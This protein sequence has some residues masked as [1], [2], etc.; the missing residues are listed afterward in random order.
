MDF[1]QLES[2]VA[3]YRQRNLTEAAKQIAISQQGLSK[4]IQRLEQE[5]ESPLFLR[6]KNRLI[7]T[8][9]GDLFYREAVDLLERYRQSMEVLARA[10][11]RQRGL[12]VGF[13]SNVAGML[14]FEKLLNRFSREFPDIPLDILSETDFVCEEK[15]LKGELDAAFC[16]GPFSSAAIKSYPLAAESLLALVNRDNPLSGREALEIGDIGECPVIA[17]DERNKDYAAL[18]R[19][20]ADQGKT[21]NIVRK[22][23]DPITHLKFVE[24]NAGISIF[25]EHWKG[26]LHLSDRVAALPVCHVQQRRLYLITNASREA[27]LE[28]R[29]FVRTVCPQTK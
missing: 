7:P 26:L 15:L 27:R 3:V 23:S 5:L 2:F 19:M 10:R 20:F 1:R 17:A 18:M 13:A 28:I 24:Q 6:V 22:S 29:Q 11:Q 14:D 8:E 12:R 4:M 25:P 16:I 21:P 9:F